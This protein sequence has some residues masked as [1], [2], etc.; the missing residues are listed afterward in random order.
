MSRVACSAGEQVV[1]ADVVY[2]VVTIEIDSG[3]ETAAIAVSRCL[4]H[5]HSDNF[6]DAH[7]VNKRAN[8]VAGIIVFTKNPVAVVDVFCG[9]VIDYNQ[10]A[11]T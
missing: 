7:T 11:N 2:A 9:L 8:E 10:G 5:R 4:G 1:I 3:G 6:I